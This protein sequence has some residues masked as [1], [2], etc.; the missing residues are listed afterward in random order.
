[1]DAAS[2][3][4][5]LVGWP[6]RVHVLVLGSPVEPELAFVGAHGL[7]ADGDVFFLRDGVL[8]L[9]ALDETVARILVAQD[10]PT[11]L[12]ADVPA[13][14]L[15]LEILGDVDFR[16]PQGSRVLVRGSEGAPPAMVRELS[17]ALHVTEA[18]VFLLPTPN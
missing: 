16:L 8:D 14:T 7:P 11:L 17:H 3:L 1:M 9:P 15:L 10:A 6:E 2:S 5:V 13:C 18:D 12:V 4:Q